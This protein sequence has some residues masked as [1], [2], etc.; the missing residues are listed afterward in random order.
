MNTDWLYFGLFCLCI[1]ATIPS[2]VHNMQ[3]QIIFSLNFFKSHLTSLSQQPFCSKWV[4]DNVNSLSEVSVPFQTWYYSSELTGEVPSYYTIDLYSYPIILLD[5]YKSLIYGQCFFF[6]QISCWC[7]KKTE[8][9]FNFL[10]NGQMGWRHISARRK[11]LGSKV[12]V[13]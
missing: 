8:R 5:K 10:G 6:L 9:Q 12:S 2:T 3:L 1:L 4:T 11:C 13:L 7:A